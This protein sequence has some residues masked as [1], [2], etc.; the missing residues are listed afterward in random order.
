MRGLNFSQTPVQRP[1]LRNPHDVNLPPSKVPV[2]L[3][4]V[5]IALFIALT[6]ASGVFSYGNH[7][8]R[9]T[10]TLGVALAWLSVLRLVC[11]SSVMG[12]FAVRSR[13]FDVTF[14]AA[15][16]ALMLYLSAT[17]ESLGS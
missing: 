15:L 7:W 9:A 6:V 4:W 10:F 8:R 17:V 3:Q 12:V 11:D 5:G 13:K 2:L 16:S 14:T 1:S